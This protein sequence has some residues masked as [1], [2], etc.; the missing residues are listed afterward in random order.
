MALFGVDIVCF[1]YDAAGLGLVNRFITL[2]QTSFGISR[3]ILDGL[4]GDCGVSQAVGGYEPAQKIINMFYFARKPGNRT[5]PLFLD[6]VVPL[7]GE[8]TGM[9]SE[10]DLVHFLLR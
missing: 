9:T 5:A 2:F 3:R 1:R 4:L 10:K 8:V 7:G 6:D